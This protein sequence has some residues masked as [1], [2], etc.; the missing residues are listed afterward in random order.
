MFYEKVFTALQENKIRY[1]VAGGVALVLHGVVRFTADLDLIVDLEHENLARFVRVMQDL[2]YRPRNP[3]KA[4]DLIDRQNRES[5]KRDK[6]MVVFSFASQASSMELVDV[7]I[8]EVYP[9]PE[10]QKELFMVNA[11]GVSIPVLSSRH[12]KQMKKASNRPRDLADIAALETM[13]RVED[14]P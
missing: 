5:W 14:K 1:A 8:E 7:F 4:E 11:K 2:R 3:L 9:F 12:L 13:E 6:G 10:I